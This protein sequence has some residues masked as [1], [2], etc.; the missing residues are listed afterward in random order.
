MDKQ[1]FDQLV[2]GVKE[3]KRHIAGNPRRGA[4]C[5]PRYPPHQVHTP[6]WRVGAFCP[7]ITAEAGQIHSRLIMAG[8]FPAACGAPRPMVSGIPIARLLGRGSLFQFL[9]RSEIRRT[10]AGMAA[11]WSF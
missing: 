5:M 2:K 3:M 6:V 4:G 10:A 8:K 9:I 1:L 7:A 11:S